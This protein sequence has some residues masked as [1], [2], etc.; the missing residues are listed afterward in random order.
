ME[1][2]RRYCQAAFLQA[3]L[4]FQSFGMQ[5]QSCF[6]KNVRQRY[7]QSAFPSGVGQRSR[8]QA[9]LVRWQLN[10]RQLRSVAQGKQATHHGSDTMLNRHGQGE[11]I[12]KQ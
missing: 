11:Q 1:G 6:H 5:L 9:V 12:G 8:R 10:L 2:Q 7:L 3:A 4:L